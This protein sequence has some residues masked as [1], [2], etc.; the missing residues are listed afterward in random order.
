[1]MDARAILPHGWHFTSSHLAANGVDIL[2]PLPR[3]DHPVR[4]IIIDFDISVRYCPGQP[5]R[6][7]DLGGRDQEPP[8]L[9]T[10]EPYDPFKLDV[11]TVANVFYK[12]FYQVRSLC[13]SDASFTL[14]LAFGVVEILWARVPDKLDQV[15]DGARF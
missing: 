4:Y 7:K 12:G 13:Y 15:D 9:A 14:R 2:D 3:I 11:F 5:H 1:M 10:G 8:E 6:I